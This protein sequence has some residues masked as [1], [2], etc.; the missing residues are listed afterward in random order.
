MR[1]FQMGTPLSPAGWGPYLKSWLPAWWQKPAAATAAVQTRVAV[2]PQ[3]IPQAASQPVPAAG[4]KER[5]YTWA[6]VNTHN[7]ADSSWIVIAGKIYDITSFKNEHP[8]G[9]ELLQER[10]GEDATASFEGVGHSDDARARL[11]TLYVGRVAST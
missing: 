2:T 7:R 4:Q 1:R 5:V 8:G 11:Q 3:S 6:E 10:F 9:I